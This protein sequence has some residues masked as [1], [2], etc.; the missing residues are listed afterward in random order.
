MLV[1][2]VLGVFSLL[3]ILAVGGGTAVLPEMKSLTVEHFHWL[4]S[5][6]FG[7]IYSLGQLAPGPNM[8]MVSVI[9]YR[10]AGYPGALAA[11]VG[12]FLPAGLLMFGVARVW[13]RYSASPFKIACERG[14]APVTIGLMLAGT[15][16]LARTVIGAWWPDAAIAVAVTVILLAVK[17]NPVILILGGGLVGYLIGS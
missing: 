9:G 10:V 3:S 15:L 2:Q 12:F 16:I 7:E 6:Q 8:L 5:E 14:L 17:I 4:T 11:L 13:D 1:L